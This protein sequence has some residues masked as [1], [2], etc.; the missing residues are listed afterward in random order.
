MLYCVE[1]VVYYII[2]DKCF[3]IIL[4]NGV[5]IDRNVG[6][7]VVIDFMCFFMCF[8]LSMWVNNSFFGFK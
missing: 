7:W 3:F 6:G 5:V 4:V 1:V 2:E 8:F